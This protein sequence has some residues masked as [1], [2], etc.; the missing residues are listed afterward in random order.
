MLL[1]GYGMKG[2]ADAAF[3]W[4][5]IAAAVRRSRRHQHA[6]PL[7][8]EWLGRRDRSRRGRASY[9]EGRRR[10]SHAWAQFNLGMLLL[11]DSGHP[12]DVATALTLFVRSARQGNAKAMNMIGRYREFGWTGRIDLAS[13]IRWYR[14][15]AMRGCFRGAAHLARFLH[16]AG[17]APR[18]RRIGI[19]NRQRT[20][21]RHFC[22]DLAAHLFAT[23]DAALAWRGA[24]S[25]EAGGGRRRAGRSVCLWK[26]AVQGRVGRS[27]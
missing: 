4:F 20:R 18:S 9:F 10:K 5:G 8:R 27:I 19:A 23:A 12:G 26:R 1:D 2:D 14:R 24:R 17:Q 7:L 25:A 13:A 15:A 11:H 3:R 16:R 6:W 21:P 22:R